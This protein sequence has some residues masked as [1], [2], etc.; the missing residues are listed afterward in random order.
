MVSIYF[1]LTSTASFHYFL[2][3]LPYFGY[4]ASDTGWTLCSIW[5]KS[6]NFCALYGHNV[7]YAHWG[8]HDIL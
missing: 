8:Q 4:N 3:H 5:T 6:A 1:S 7:F 2:S